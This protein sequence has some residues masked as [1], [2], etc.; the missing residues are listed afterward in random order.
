MKG[1]F[2]GFGAFLIVVLVIVGKI[3]G[4]NLTYVQVTRS[5]FVPEQVQI[6]VGESVYFQNKTGQGGIVLCLGQ[7][8]TCALHAAGPSDLQNRGFTLSVAETHPIEFDNQ[9]AYT[10][11]SLQNKNMMVVVNVSPAN[12]NSGGCCHSGGG[13]SGSGGN[14]GSGGD[15]GSGGGGGGE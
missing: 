7:K 4:W 8:G 5:A 1:Y 13:S 12:D 11:T 14:D 6:T 9:G 10:I 2:I 3:F 15:G